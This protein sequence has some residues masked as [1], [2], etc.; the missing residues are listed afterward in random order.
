MGV[1]RRPAGVCI[2]RAVAG[3]IARHANNKTGVGWPG[4]GTIAK[5]TAFKRTAV[6]A[7]IKELERGRARH[8]DPLQGRQKEHGKSVSTPPMGGAT[9]ELGG[10]VDGGGVVRQTDPN[11]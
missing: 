2:A 11:Q 4:M 10:V 5:E 6:I 9:G 8:G 1:A 3:C 7:A